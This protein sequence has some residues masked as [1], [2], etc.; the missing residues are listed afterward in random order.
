MKR[1]FYS[2][3]VLALAVAFVSCS[4]DDDHTFI[5][6]EESMELRAEA[7][8]FSDVNEYKTSVT[9]QCKAGNHENCDILNDGTHQAC[10]YKEHSGT[11]H[12]GTHH[13]GTDHGSH[14]SNGHSHGSHDN[15]HHH[16]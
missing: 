11:K 14:D 5:S 3:A 4:S 15:E 13:N 12:D 16:K 2:L 6:A 7:L 9:E 8:G 10:A 1:K